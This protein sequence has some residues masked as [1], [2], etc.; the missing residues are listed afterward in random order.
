MRRLGW[1]GRPWDQ[2]LGCHSRSTPTAGAVVEGVADGWWTAEAP[3]LLRHCVVQLMGISV[4]RHHRQHCRAWHLSRHDR[5]VI[6]H[7][8][9]CGAASLPPQQKAHYQHHEH[10]SKDDAGTLPGPAR[11]LIDPTLPAAH[12]VG[13]LVATGWK[14][15]SVLQCHT[16][17][18]SWQL[19]ST[20]N[21]QQ[22]QCM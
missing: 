10:C 4:R 3:A 13:Q 6:R 21:K 20:A 7:S 5:C 9:A 11:V 12:T 14:A 15:R 8:R 22:S 17:V 19:S 16:A 2:R 18:R 1:V